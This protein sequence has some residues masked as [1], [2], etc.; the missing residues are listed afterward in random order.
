MEDRIHTRVI[1]NVSASLD[2]NGHIING[3]VENLSMSGMLIN[4]CDPIPEGAEAQASIYLSGA[5][6]ELSLNMICKVIRKGKH[7]IAV[8]FTQM[9]IDSYIHLKNIVAFNKMD[10][11]KIMKEFES[12]DLGESL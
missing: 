4:T 9:D 8:Q 3:N 2:F 10:E 11:E 12:S 7:C 6:S 1:F 5:T